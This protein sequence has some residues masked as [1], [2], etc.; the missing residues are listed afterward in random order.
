MSESKVYIKSKFGISNVTIIHTVKVK[1]PHHRHAGDKGERRYSSYSFLT[2]AL[3]GSE[4]SAS[5]PGCSLPPGKGPLVPTVQE[6]GWASEVVWTERLEEKFF[7]S[8]RNPTP[9]T[10]S[11]ARH[12]TD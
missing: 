1:L 12:Y 8:A 9:V 6:A 2:S 3:D 10:Q 5:Q 7:A 11:I 4:W